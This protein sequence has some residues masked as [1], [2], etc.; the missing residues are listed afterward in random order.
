M[1]GNIEKTSGYKK[2]LHILQDL[3]QYDEDDMEALCE[4]YHNECTPDMGSAEIWGVLCDNS[5]GIRKADK[6]VEKEIRALLAEI[7]AVKAPKKRAAKKTDEELIVYTSK[8]E[9]GDA[10]YEEVYKDGVPAFIDKEGTY[11]NEIAVDGITHRPINGDELTER[12][13]LLPSGVEDYGTETE[14][15]AEIQA[16]IHAVADVSPFFEKISAYYIFLSYLYDELDTLPYLRVLGDTGCGKSRY[17]DAVGRLC[18]KATIVSGAITPAPIYRLIRKWGGTIIIDE[19]DLRASDAQ[20]EVVKI[21]NCGFETGRPVVRCLMDNPD[22]LQFL[23]TFGPKILS[24]RKRF[25]D[26]ALESRCLTETMRETN[27]NN[28]PYVLPKT[29]YEEEVH[30]RN[31]LLSYRFQNHGKVNTAQTL[32]MDGV[33]I[34]NR[35]KQAMSSFLILFADNEE[36]YKEFISFLVEYNGE[37][38]EERATTNEGGIIHA[39]HILLQEKVQRDNVSKGIGGRTEN[40]GILDAETLNDSVDGV[41]IT[42]SDIQEVMLAALGYQEKYVTTRSIGRQLRILGML[43][44]KTWNRE[45]GKSKSLLVLEPEHLAKLFLKYIPDPD[46]DSSVHSVT[47]ITSVVSTL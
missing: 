26:Q 10:L 8:I 46:S 12:G 38:V 3:A 1:I 44:Q 4:V 42:A 2:L 11:Y 14:L 35:L 34:E 33:K 30:L 29:F 28:L 24:S 6:A 27:R 47:S 16:H 41:E 32:K 23:P 25:T 37:L 15:L 20:N 31:K 43:T 5:S 36:V 39:I 19:G 21:L 13:I 17:Q 9:D 7:N 45:A 18:Y 22:S 40:P